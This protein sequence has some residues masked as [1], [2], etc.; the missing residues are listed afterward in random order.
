[1]I[2]PLANIRELPFKATID[3][4]G[5]LT[6]FTL[7]MTVPSGDV[8]TDMTLSRTAP[9]PRAL[10]LVRRSGAV[11]GVWSSRWPGACSRGPDGC[12]WV[13]AHCPS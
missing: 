4:S 1:M 8:V 13:L 2:M 6:T 11:P 5:Y 9:A 10:G 12:R 3:P 7:T